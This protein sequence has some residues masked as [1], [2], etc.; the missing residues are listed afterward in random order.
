MLVVIVALEGCSSSSKAS[1][2]P[3]AKGFGYQIVDES[4]SAEKEVL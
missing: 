3:E 4:H 1:S 2:S